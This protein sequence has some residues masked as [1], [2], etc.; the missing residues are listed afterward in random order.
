MHL[1]RRGKDRLAENVAKLLLHTDANTT[2]NSITSPQK[3]V[4]TIAPGEI[5]LVE[6]EMGD[7]IEQFRN[8]PSVAFAHSISSDFKDYRHMSAGVAV[9]FRSKFGKPQPKDCVQNRLAYQKKENEAVVYSLVTK[10]RYW[11]KPEEKDYNTAFKQLTQDFAARGMKTLICS[12]MGC[13]RD[14]VLPKHFA[15]NIVD[16]QFATGA[17]VCVV[18]CDQPSARR[19]LRRG[20]SH[21]VFM[22]KLKEAIKDCQENRQ[23]LP[24]PNP[25]QLNSD[26]PTPSAPQLLDTSVEKCADDSEISVTLMSSPLNFQKY[27]YQNTR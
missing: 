25:Q 21:P 20:L 27:L 9:I 24:S 23:T 12:P 8:D 19:A 10:V 26:A 2:T 17:H 22:R 11:G 13:V 14:L 1:N 3:T 15:K 16:F 6:A 5:Q 7:V 18:S 4:F